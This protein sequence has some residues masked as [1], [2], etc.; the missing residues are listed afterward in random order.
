ME[1]ILEKLLQF[2]PLLVAGALPS[3]IYWR[4]RKDKQLESERGERGELTSDIV[5]EGSSIRKDLRTMLKEEQLR[6]D[7]RDKVIENLRSEIYDLKGTINNVS[8]MR[9]TLERDLAELTRNYEMLQIE[10]ERRGHQK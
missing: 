5:E 3:Y 8:F 7:N 9:I 1:W 10:L 6:S 4:N 2:S